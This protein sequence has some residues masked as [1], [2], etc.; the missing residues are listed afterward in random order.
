MSLSV[1]RSGPLLEEVERRGALS[2]PAEG[3]ARAVLS[4]QHGGD[5]SRVN[6]RD[7]VRTAAGTARAVLTTVVAARK[8][9]FW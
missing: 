3:G 8:H 5:E 1:R 9:L 7:V 4:S 2:S 6:K